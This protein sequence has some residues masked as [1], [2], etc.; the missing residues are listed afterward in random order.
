MLP[1]NVRRSRDC[2]ASEA[3]F[4]C[5]PGPSS[6]R[7]RRFPRG[8]LRA[9]FQGI[10]RM[11]Q[12]ILAAAL[13]VALSGC[14]TLFNGQSQA[15]TITSAPEGAQVTVSNRAGQRV[16]VGET[17]VTLTLKR[18]AG[19]FKSEVY[20]LAFS[21]PGFADQQMTIRGSTS[22][23]YFGN[24]LLGGLIGMLAVDPATGAMYSLPKSVT[25]SL[26]AQDTVGAIDEARLQI[27]S[28]ESLSAEQRAQAV[29]LTPQ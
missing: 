28:M 21:K 23:W 12:V 18:G 14:A 4:P 3:L 2:A 5:E 20:T 8:R 27:V 15:I 17:P 24:I 10:H 26:E 22:G 16:H 9:F 7:A 13:A 6:I 29:R 1:L 25:A 19:Y 11:K